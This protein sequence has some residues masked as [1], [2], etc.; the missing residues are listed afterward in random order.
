[1]W[2][3]TEHRI[4]VSPGRNIGWETHGTGP[5]LVVL[6]GA[7]RA[8]RHLRPLALALRGRFTVHLVDRNGRGLSLPRDDAGGLAGQARDIAAVIEA[9][10][11][12]FL[13]GHSAGGMVA[14]AAAGISRLDGLAVYEP[15]VSFDG[16]YV[17]PPADEMVSAIEQGDFAGG[18][19]ELA[20]VVGALPRWV[21]DAPLHWG[22]SLLLAAGAGRGLRELLPLVG[23][24]IA[25]SM[26]DDG[27]AGR[28]SH[29]TLPVLVMWGARSPAFLRENAQKLVAALPDGH[30]FELA[31]QGHLAPDLT[32]PRAV[33]RKITNFLLG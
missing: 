17:R 4:A 16:S 15:S 18:Q 6:H 14:L 22:L 19:I 29:L 13:F 27:P 33:A 10:G 31:G 12:R 26:A 20:R 21:P 3:G 11:A 24:D 8:R 9:T 7:G 32:A 23:P 5:G 30:G 2:F 1:M 25:Q 28:F